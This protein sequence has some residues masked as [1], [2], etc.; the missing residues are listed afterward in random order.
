MSDVIT[1]RACPLC[2]RTIQQAATL[3]G[4]CWKHIPP[5]GPDGAILASWTPPA[6][7]RPW[8]KIWG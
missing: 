1:T 7:H 8:W 4:F 6:P 5:V 3:C 2:A